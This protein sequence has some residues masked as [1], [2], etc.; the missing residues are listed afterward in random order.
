VTNLQNLK[1]L[2]ATRVL[3]GVNKL[4]KL[5]NKTTQYQHINYICNFYSNSVVTQEVWAFN[6]WS[7]KFFQEEKWIGCQSWQLQITFV[8]VVPKENMWNMKWQNKTTDVIEKNAFIQLDLCEQLPHAS[9]WGSW[10]GISFS[11]DMSTKLGSIF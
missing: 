2:V 10:Y 4:Y 3:N 11:D 5:D 7:L 1:K 8:V 6:L 9:L